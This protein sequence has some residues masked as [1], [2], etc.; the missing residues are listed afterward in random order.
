MCFG[1]PML[2]I[3]VLWTFYVYFT[4]PYIMGMLRNVISWTIVRGVFQHCSGAICV[5]CNPSRQTP[6]YVCAFHV[7]ECLFMWVFICVCLCTCRY[8]CV[9]VHA[10]A[11]LCVCLYAYGC[12]ICVCMCLNLWVIRMHVRTCVFVCAYAYLY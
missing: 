10:Y 11:L 6:M 9:C 7:G 2:S 1:I 12:N 5:F 8:V 4:Y 3:C